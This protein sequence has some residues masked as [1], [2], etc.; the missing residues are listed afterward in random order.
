MKE[1]YN[2]IVSQ[3][4]TL[5]KK[6]SKKILLNFLSKICEPYHPKPPRKKKKKKKKIKKKTKTRPKSTKQQKSLLKT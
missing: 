1:N 2:K 6:K 4:M 5:S 3:K